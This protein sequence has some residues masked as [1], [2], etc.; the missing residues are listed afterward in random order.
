MYICIL[1]NPEQ[2]RV[3]HRLA[4]WT[5]TDTSGACA[6]EQACIHIH[7]FIYIYIYA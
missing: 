6:C 4:S 1:T 7:V 2:A 5:L 3:A